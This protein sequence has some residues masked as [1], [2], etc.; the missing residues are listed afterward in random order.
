MTDPDEV[1]RQ[2]AAESLAVD[3][4]TGW[5]ERLYSAADAGAAVVPWDRGAA[6]PLI[7]EWAQGRG[8]PQQQEQAQQR[9]RALVVGA[10]L[11]FDAEYI[12]GLGFETTAF[13]ISPTA[14]RRAQERSERVRFRTADL[15][16]PP[17]EW[18]GAFDLV[19]ESLTVQSMPVGPRKAAIHNVAGFVAPG[20]TL[21]VVAFAQDEHDEPFEGPPWPL[22]RADIAAFGEGLET[23]AVERVEGRW[24]A[25]FRR[26]AA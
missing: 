7:V 25:E 13:D 3:D 6:H 4:P 15:L 14:V 8:R 5:F 23:V 20:G 11:G 2:L 1:S 12:A 26:P 22:T 19:V 24:R 17:A 21:L 10:G 16:D 9:E 18:H